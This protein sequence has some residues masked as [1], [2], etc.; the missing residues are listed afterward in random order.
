VGN[1]LPKWSE[2]KNAEFW[3]TISKQ[4]I[5]IKPDLQDVN[6]FRYAHNITGGSQEFIEALSFEH[7]LATQQ[8][9]SYHDAQAHLTKISGPENGLIFLSPEDYLLGILD[10]TGELMRFAIT[11]IA[12]DHKLPAGDPKTSPKRG[13]ESNKRVAIDKGEEMEIDAQPS[14]STTEISLES[15]PEASSQQGGGCRTVLDDLR[16][17]RLQLEMFEAPKGSKLAM[18]MEK[19]MTV[20]RQS[21]EKVEKELYNLTVRGSERPKGWVPGEEADRRTAVES[22]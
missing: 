17:L 15:G 13:N 18:D 12:R 4:Y 20:M 7:Y 2:K 5:S 22:Y 21:V 19:K 3:N 11:S 6:A 10:M 8:L 14:T 16:E 9:I 1:G